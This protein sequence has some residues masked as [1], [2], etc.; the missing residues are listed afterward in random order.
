MAS[1]WNPWHGCKKKSEG[2]RNCY[3]YR[4]DAKKGLDAGQVY[5]TEKFDY[6]IETK[7]N[8]EYK[9]KAGNLFFT[10]FTSDFLLQEADE[11][12]KD[13]WKII[14]ERSDCDFFFLTKRP[15]RFLSCI[16]EDWGDGYENIHMGV[17]CENQ[18]MADE[19]I[20]ILLSLPLKHRCIVLAPMLEPMNIES[21]LNSSIGVV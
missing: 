20:P 15:E 12:R 17:S 6:P 1:A 9:T 8:G 11:W 14:K 16:P 5:K 13:A 19:R 4:G 2:C 18:Q 21:Y 10:C 7:K 3:I